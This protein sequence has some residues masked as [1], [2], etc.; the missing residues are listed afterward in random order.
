M[1]AAVGRWG[2]KV[3]Y[4]WLTG[5][6]DEITQLEH[7]YGVAGEPKGAS[8]RAALSTPVYLIDRSGF[9]R[10]GYLYPFFPTV[11]AGDL[12]RLYREHD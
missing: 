10:A 2:L 7:E 5:T 11:L 9:E 1:R 3:P 8:T 4:E 6:P 12:E